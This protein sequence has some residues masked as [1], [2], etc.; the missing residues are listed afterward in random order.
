MAN[1]L[2]RRLSNIDHKNIPHHDIILVIEQFTQQLR[3]SEYNC[4]ESRGH[5]VD[6][7]RGWRNKIERRLTEGQEF[8]RLAKNTLQRRVKKKLLENE[9]WYKTEKTENTE[10][11][12]ED[13]ELPEG[14]KVDKN[15]RGQNRKNEE[16]K[17][18]KGRIKNKVKGVMFLPFTHHSELA[19]H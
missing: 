10:D 18:D 9:T 1:K 11:K 8:D 17:E 13:W 14:W 5:V 6:G 16:D 15:K 4:K 19:I 12:P 3:N 7:I 2:L